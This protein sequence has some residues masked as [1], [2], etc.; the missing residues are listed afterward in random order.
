MQNEK[1]IKGNESHMRRKKPTDTWRNHDHMKNG[2]G[3]SKKVHRTH[4]TLHAQI[5]GISDRIER[6]D[7]RRANRKA[8]R[9]V[10]TR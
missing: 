8:G 4:Y 5:V 7:I 2:N 3:M 6:K 1:H 10:A 9:R